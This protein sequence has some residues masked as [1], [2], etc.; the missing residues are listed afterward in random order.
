MS[1]RSGTFTRTMELA[2]A[3]LGNR[4]IV[5]SDGQIHWLAPRNTSDSRPWTN[6]EGRWALAR[7]LEPVE[8]PTWPELML[9][10]QRAGLSPRRLLQ[11]EMSSGSVRGWAG[12]AADRNSGWKAETWRWGSDP[13]SRERVRVWMARIEGYGTDREQVL[14]QGLSNTN[15]AEVLTW[16]LRLGLTCESPA[17]LA[18]RAA[19]FEQARGER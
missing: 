7:T 14:R 8:G 3:Q 12:T 1:Y 19:A 2:A 9:R 18:A 6:A 13:E 5:N 17:G 10:A 11:T 16:A 15:P 4:L